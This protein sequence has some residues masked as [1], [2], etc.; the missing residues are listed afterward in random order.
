[1]FK[2]GYDTDTLGLGAYYTHCDPV[3]RVVIRVY[4]TPITGYEQCVGPGE[5][6]LGLATFHIWAQYVR[7]C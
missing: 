5:T 6:Y 7:L 1:M 3:T 2:C 4:T